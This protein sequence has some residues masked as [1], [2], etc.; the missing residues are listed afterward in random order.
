MSKLHRSAHIRR[1]KQREEGSK[2]EYMTRRQYYRRIRNLPPYV[3]L[4]ILQDNYTT[5]EHPGFCRLNM[6]V[7]GHAATATF[8]TRKDLYAYIETVKKVHS[9]KRGYWK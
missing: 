8:K 4:A 7:Y 5:M 3:V 9:E 1:I 6:E 2:L